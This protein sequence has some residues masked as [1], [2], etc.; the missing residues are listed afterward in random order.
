VGKGVDLQGV[1]KQYDKVNCGQVMQG[2]ERLAF[3]L[4]TA[5]PS[6]NGSTSGWYIVSG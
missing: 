1:N 2:C 3:A 5:A 4:S 6:G